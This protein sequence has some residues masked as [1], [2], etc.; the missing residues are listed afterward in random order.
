MRIWILTICWLA[1]IATTAFAQSGYAVL[2][3]ESPVGAGEIDPGIGIHTFSINQTV[4]LT[5]VPKAGYHFVYWLG[6]VSDPTANRTTIAVD[7]P[8]IIIAIFERNEYE[9]PGDSMAVSSGP[10]RLTRRPYES[11]GIRSSGS[12]IQ[13]NYNSPNYPDN[14]PDNEPDNPP[15]VPDNPPPVPEVPEPATILFLG[16]GASCL[17]INRKKQTN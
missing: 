17:V 10:E 12:I 11:S 4:T 15:P 9:L 16:L 3:E 2:V 13:R 1:A 8:K 6:D 14:P 7:G 5:T